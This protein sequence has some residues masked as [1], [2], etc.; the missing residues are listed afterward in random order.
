MDPGGSAAVSHTR[1]HLEG[2]DMF[3]T[4]FLLNQ[5]KIMTKVITVQR[6]QY[7][8][9]VQRE[10]RNRR[11]V[12]W[13]IHDSKTETL[14]L[15]QKLRQASEFINQH[16]A[17]FERDKVSVAGLYEAADASG[18]RVDGFHKY[19]YRIV[20]T[21]LSGAHSIFNEMRKASG[22]NSAMILTKAPHTYML[23]S[24]ESES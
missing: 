24:G 7:L 1:V 20:R 12:A 17:D 23:G 2:P 16:L 15:S 19:R 3:K 13:I 5:V 4:L 10:R 21:P 11:D 6:A 22:V 18:N 9:N 8:Q 14:L